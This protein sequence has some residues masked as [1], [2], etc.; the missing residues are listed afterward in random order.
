MTDEFTWYLTR[1]SGLLGWVLLAVATIWG[2]LLASR[3]LERRPSPAWLL[4]LHRHLGNLTLLL[5]VVHVGAIVIDDFVDYTLAEV[6][7]PFRSDEE[8]TAVALGVVSAW[9]L[10]VVQAS[11]WMRRRLDQRLWRLLHL[12]SAPLLILVLVHG[13]LVGTDADNP[14]VVIVSLVLLA[15]IAVIF[16]VRVRY[17]R[18]PL[19]DA[20]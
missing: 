1:T 7:I 17:G 5:T 13:W 14:I 12:L 16:A 6:L 10:V 9:L 3:V 15:E 19:T 20:G 8:T 2:L 4:D 18:R 11:S